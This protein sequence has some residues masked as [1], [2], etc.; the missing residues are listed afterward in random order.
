MRSS[1]PFLAL[2]ALSL[3]F[4]LSACSG[5]DDSKESGAGDQPSAGGSQ[6][7]QG[8]ST[9]KCRVNLQV[10]GAATATL[11]DGA[12]VRTV[13]DTG[14]SVFDV[15]KGGTRVVVYSADDEQPAS[16]NATVAGTTYRTKPGD[17]TGLKVDRKGKKAS[18]D[19]D[20]FAGDAAVHL[21]GTF[22]CKGS[23]TS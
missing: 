13:S 4:S 5:N 6:S 19:A 11:T 2:A 12:S 15:A 20:A 10:T 22:S 21:D 9:G 8:H 14:T 18:V 16:V 1:R 23:A 7:P 17:G 3:A